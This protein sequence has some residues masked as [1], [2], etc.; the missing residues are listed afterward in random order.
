M[1]NLDRLAGDCA[2]QFTSPG[3]AAHRVQSFVRIPDQVL[4]ARGVP[5]R[6]ATRMGD[7]WAVEL[8]DSEV[9]WG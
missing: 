3:I 4:R 6:F 5:D 1:G 8:D 9:D 2:T 7:G